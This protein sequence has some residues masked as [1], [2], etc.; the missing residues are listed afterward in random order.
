MD[1]NAREIQAGWNV[2]GS[3]DAKVGDV[4]EVG[5]NYLLVQKGWLFTRDIYV[6]MSAIA[7]IEEDNIRLNVTK[8]DV[9]S[10]GWDTIPTEDATTAYGTSS[11]GSMND[12]TAASTTTDRDYTTTVRDDMAMG[13]VGATGS[14]MASDVVDTD[15]TA[16]YADTRDRGTD[17]MRIPVIEE[18]ARV[19]KRA[20]EGGGVEVTTH[21]EETPVNEQVTLHDERVTVDRRPV[22][23]PVTD[24]D[25]AAMRD[26]TLEVTEHREE[27]VVD[28]QARVVGEVVINKDARERTENV[29]D[30][31]RRTDVEVEE[32]PR[33]TTTSSVV[34]TAHV[35][36]GDVSGMSGAST[37]DTNRSSTMDTSSRVSGTR[38]EGAI[39]RGLSKAENAA[40]RAVGA[41]LNRDGDVGVR[42]PRNNV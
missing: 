22:D 14:T 12:R 13:S 36:A 37:M 39:E 18:E 28:K 30:T 33:Q 34:E 31:V 20:V 24:A 32:L 25:L 40:E 27:A 35:R 4:A 19:G 9:A 41:D 29:Q 42:D 21:I 16:A 5:P 15:R 23:R 8:D 11:I 3:D 17:E 2:Y 10:M 1:W 38:D 7:S 26:E 6:P